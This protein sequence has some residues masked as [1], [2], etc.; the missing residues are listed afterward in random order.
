MISRQRRPAGGDR[1]VPRRAR[2]ALDVPVRPRAR[3]CR[4]S[5]GCARRPTRVHDPYVPAR[6]HAVARDLTIH[7]RLRRLLV[8]GPPDAS[9]SCARTCARSARDPG[10]LGGAGAREPGPGWRSSTTRPADADAAA[11]LRTRATASRPACSPPGCR[12]AKP[13]RDARRADARIVDP[14]GAPARVSLVLPPDGRAAAVRRPRRPAGAPRRCSRG[15]P[16]DA[17]TTLLTRRLALRGLAARRARRGCRPPGRGPVRADLP[18]R[19]CCTSAPGV[20]G[21]VPWP[22][23]PMIERY[24]SAQPWPL[25]RFA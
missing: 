13:V 7:A 3:R 24:G 19:G 16:F 14:A 15:E 6:L 17:V 25:D 11:R 12:R 20:L 9:R 1:G 10:R 5:S 21:R 22:A 8:L 18:R 23:G 2:R 4:R